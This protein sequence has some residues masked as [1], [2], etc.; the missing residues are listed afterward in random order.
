MPFRLPTKLTLEPGCRSHLGSIIQDW[1]FQRVLLVY[2]HGLEATP[3]P[4]EMGVQI[5]STGAELFHCTDIEP[6][7]RHST[8]NRTADQALVSEVDLVVGLG[9]GSVLDA[10]K[11]VAMLVPNGGGIEDYEGR[12]K[13]HNKPLP[14]VAIPTTCGTGSEVTWVSVITV[15][16][17]E[18]KISVKGDGMFPT[19]ALVDADM[20][21]SLPAELVAWTGVDALTHAMEAYIGT[22]ANPTS[23][24]L[25]EKAVGLLLRY[26][27]RA[28]L[29]IRGA[30]IA[31]EAVMRASTIA[32]VAFGNADVGG[33]HCLSETLGGIWDVPH[34]LG[35]AMLLAPVMRFHKEAAR[36]RLAELYRHSLGEPS[37]DA[38]E[39]MIRAVEDLV[40]V[41]GVP[42]FSS[43][44]IGEQHYER[45]AQGAVNNNSNGSNPQPMGISEYM[46]ILT[47]LVS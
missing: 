18:R 2:D 17:D 5:R 41:L 14:F 22:Q 46:E 44:D 43:L 31:R 45:I 12:N 38:A 15:E 16:E 32:G 7:P 19:H 47:D 34:G 10:A 30:D 36:K 21:T 26:L 42:E 40:E 11:A 23:D 35:N 13:F 3:W 6:N 33:V 9:G 8:V 1:G 4:E 28:A 24:A 37:G 20:L 25:A 29:D 39:S 27:P